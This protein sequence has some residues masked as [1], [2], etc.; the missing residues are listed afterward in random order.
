MWAVEDE[1]ARERRKS[2]K[3]RMDDRR[4]VVEGMNERSEGRREG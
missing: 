1:S 3:D 2:N 4:G